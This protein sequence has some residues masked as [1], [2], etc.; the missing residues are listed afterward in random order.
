MNK[1]IVCK[2][3]KHATTATINDVRDVTFCEHHQFPTHS[4]FTCGAFV[5]KPEAMN[6]ALPFLSVADALKY[7]LLLE[8]TLIE[9]D[10][11]K[12]ELYTKDGNFFVL[13]KPETMIEYLYL[14]GA[15]KIKYKLNEEYIASQIEDEIELVIE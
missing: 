3:C 9:N 7:F 1:K 5:T 4:T 10:W 6:I 8:I 2:H 12:L 15:C 13:P 11:N 14:L